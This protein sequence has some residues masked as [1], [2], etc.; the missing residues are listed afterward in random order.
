MLSINQI[1]QE[2]VVIEHSSDELSQMISE[3]SQELR[4]DTQR[5]AALV[6]G[7]STGEQA[8]MALNVASRSLAEAAVSMKALS[9]TCVDCSTH[10]AG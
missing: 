5:I 3:A 6:Q 9:R 1:I 4:K 2:V 7:S 10:L 8:L